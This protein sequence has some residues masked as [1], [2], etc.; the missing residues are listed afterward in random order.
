MKNRAI[1]TAS[2]VAVLISL[3][4]WPLAALAQ[5]RSM[6]EWEAL[7]RIKLAGAAL[8]LSIVDAHWA[9]DPYIGKLEEDTSFDIRVPLHRGTRYMLIGVCDDD[10]R[11]LNM[12]MYDEDGE[13][14][15]QNSGRTTTPD[16][17]I[18]PEQT[19]RFTVRMTMKRC[20]EDPC[21]YGLGVYS[22]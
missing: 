5:R 17:E 11:N 19:Q 15:G 14:V 16:L 8:L 21:Y 12:K 6:T 4:V 20:D 2:A 3:L 18:I 13:F 22:K 9:Y 7:V 1:F 10:C